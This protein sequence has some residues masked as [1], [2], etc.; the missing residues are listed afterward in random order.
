MR[1]RFCFSLGALAVVMA[2]ILCA[3]TLVAAQAQSGAAAKTATKPGMSKKAW[4]MPRTPDGQPEL[5]GVW[6]NN[7][8]TPL[9]RPKELAGKEYYTEAELAELQKRERERLALDDKEGEPAANHSGVEG[10]PAENVHYDHAQ[11]GLDWLQSKV[12]WNRR[13]SLIVGP[14][15]TIPP[16][17]AEARKRLAESAAKEKGH[18]FDGPENRPLAA[19]CI[20]RPNTGPPLLPTRYNS[21]LQIVQG[22]GYVA[23]ETEEI[24]D[25]RIIPLDG[26]PHLPKNIRQWMGDSVGHWEGNTLVVDTTNFTDLNPFPGAQNLH[27]I[28]RITRAG[29]DTILYQFTVEDPGMWIKPWSGEVPIKKIRGQLYEYACHE[30][31]YGLANTLRGA[32]VAEAEAAPKNDESNSHGFR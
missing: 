18:E 8:V 10:A 3:P 26:R 30:G 1:N 7:S 32:R 15:G 6:T 2:A 23:I 20:A 16:L 19:R 9:Q 4:T 21:N 29:E 28:E 24:H 5:Q 17:T 13:T 14:D 11:F 25:V 31:N 27:V 22:P 12:A